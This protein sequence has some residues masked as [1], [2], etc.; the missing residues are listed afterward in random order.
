MSPDAEKHPFQLGERASSELTA[1]DVEKS[2]QIPKPDSPPCPDEATNKARLV[3][4]D[5]E[6]GRSTPSLAIG[7]TAVKVPRSKRRGLFGTL[8]ILAEIEEPQEYP[9]RVKWFITFVVAMAAVAAPLGSTLIF[10]IYH[11][12][13]G[14]ESMTD[15][16]PS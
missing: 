4:D 5:L 13:G 15:L 14:S 2:D 8:T 7:P 9:R 1:V 16:L 10:R 12:L 11:R 6:I 3:Q